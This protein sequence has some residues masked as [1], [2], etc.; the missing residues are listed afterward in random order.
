MLY[1]FLIELL[2]QTK[3]S[4]ENLDRDQVVHRHAGL[5]QYSFKSVEKKSQFFSN[6]GRRNSGTGINADTTGHVQGLPHLHGIAEWQWR[7]SARKVNVLA[8]C[9]ARSHVWDPPGLLIGQSASRA[10]IADG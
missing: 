1:V 9:D 7:F 8:D 10:I 4:R 6:L 3:V 2:P 5:R